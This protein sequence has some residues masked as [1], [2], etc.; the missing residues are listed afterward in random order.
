MVP[1][2]KMC[3]NGRSGAS[4]GACPFL[5]FQLRKSRVG[6]LAPFILTLLRFPASR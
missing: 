1:R 5:R 6:S 2:L 4:H 3:E